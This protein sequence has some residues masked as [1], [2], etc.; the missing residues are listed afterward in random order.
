[1]VKRVLSRIEGADQLYL[2]MPVQRGQGKMGLDFHG[3]YRG[4]SFYIETKAP[5]NDLTPRQETTREEM[6]QSGA[7]VFTVHDEQEMGPVL[8]WVE[9][10][11]LMYEA[12]A[13][14]TR[15]QAE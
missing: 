6:L 13:E 7:P 9:R 1:M 8:D 3:T 4:M 14:R 15:P 12:L 11:D 5:G 10:V 2:F